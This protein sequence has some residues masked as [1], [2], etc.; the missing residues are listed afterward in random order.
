VPDAAAVLSVADEHG[1][2]AALPRNAI[3]AQ[4][5]TI[6]VAGTDRVAKLAADLRPDVLF[7]DAPVSGSKGPA[8][9]GAL[10]IFASGPD[11]ARAR[12]TPVF[13]ALGQRTMWVGPAGFGSRLKLVN[14]TMLAFTAEGVAETVSLAHGFGLTTQTVIDAIGRGPLGSPWANAKMQRMQHGEYSAEFALAL[15][16][17][18]VRL[19]LD[20]GGGRLPVAAQLAGIWQDVVDR[21]FG[22][23]DVTVVARALDD[24]GSAR[25]REPRVT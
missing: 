1:M 3:W 24:A 20:A 11:E 10:T 19:A 12:L 25:A 22:G 4:M 6:G 18:D 8:E 7:V 21:G 13:D 16:L 9:Q 15:A 17:K 14:N 5:S 23:Q 2:L